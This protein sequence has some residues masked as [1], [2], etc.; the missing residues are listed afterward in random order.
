MITVNSTTIYLMY[1][2]QKLHF[3]NEKFNDKAAETVEV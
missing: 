2:F 1:K 3:A